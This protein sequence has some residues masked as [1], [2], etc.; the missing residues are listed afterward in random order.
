MLHLKSEQNC[1]TE[2]LKEEEDAPFLSL[3]ARGAPRCVHMLLTQHSA[4][5]PKV[6]SAVQGGTCA[7]RIASIHLLHLT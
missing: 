4:T 5:K 3:A 7:P 1:V 2:M 6:M